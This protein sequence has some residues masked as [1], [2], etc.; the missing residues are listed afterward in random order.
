MDKTLRIYLVE[1]VGTFGLV[2]IGAGAV[3]ANRAAQVSE[4]PAP[5][6]V[7]IALATGF[8]Y[9]AGL[10]MTQSYGGG[11]YLNP[12]ITLMLWVFKRLDGLKTACLIGVQLLGAALAGGLVRLVFSEIVLD[13]ARMGTPHIN[14]KALGE[15][16]YNASVLLK[17]VGME[18][19][20]T[21]LL[22]FFVFATLIDPRAPKVLGPVGRWLGGLWAGLVAAGATLAGFGLTGAALNPARWFGTVI[23]E[24]T[25]PP[26]QTQRPLEG[27]LVYWFGP[28]VG[29]LLA[30]V[31]YTML[32]LP[33]EEPAAAPVSSHAKVAAG[34]GATLFRSKK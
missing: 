27:H 17:G 10:A 26:L 14:L 32:I 13:L 24:L 21:F 15:A 34:V 23:W 30:G 22:T 1:L 29:A 20:L 12:A 4:W 7:G 33:A 5:G 16:G 28:I 8:A 25:I 9:A 19:G 3:C 6:L 11:G 31:A 2:L 18:M